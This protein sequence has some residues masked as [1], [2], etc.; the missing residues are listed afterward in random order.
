MS[1]FNLKPTCGP[2]GRND[3]AVS[4]D[5]CASK[6]LLFNFI[7]GRIKKTLREFNKQGDLMSSLQLWKQFVPVGGSTQLPNLWT[8]STE[9]WT[10]CFGQSYCFLATLRFFLPYKWDLGTRVQLCIP[11]HIIKSGVVRKGEFTVPIII[12]SRYAE[13]WRVTICMQRECF[14]MDSW[15]VTFFISP[16]ARNV[17]GTGWLCTGREIQ[18]S[19]N[20][21]ARIPTFA[22]V[23]LSLTQLERIASQ[24]SNYWNLLT[25]DK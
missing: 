23:T 18:Q 15:K 13:Q 8:D 22:V 16:R 21:W 11:V 14:Q 20:Q 4:H 25:V 1:Q 24:F 19:G 5:C 12:V 6:R 2:I 10:R 17:I 9:V 7:R 3:W